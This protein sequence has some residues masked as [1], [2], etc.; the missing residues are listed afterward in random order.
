MAQKSP[1]LSSVREKLRINGVR[2]IDIRFK[3]QIED[4]TGRRASP[5]PRGGDRKSAGYKA[6]RE[7]K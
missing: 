5:L 7:N 1:L 3:Q 4:Q 2:V 6:K